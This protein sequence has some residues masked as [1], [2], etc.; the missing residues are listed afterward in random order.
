MT[1]MKRTHAV[2]GAEPQ[3]HNGMQRNR[4][5]ESRAIAAAKQNLE[6]VFTEKHAL[7]GNFDSANSSLKSMKEYD[8]R[9]EDYYFDSSMPYVVASVAHGLIRITALMHEYGLDMRAIGPEGENA[10]SMD[11]KENRGI[12]VKTLLEMGCNPNAVQKGTPA[13]VDAEFYH[14]ECGDSKS[15]VRYLK[16]NGADINALDKF[17][18]NALI[19]AIEHGNANRAIELVEIGAVLTKE[20]MAFAKERD[21]D[22]ASVQSAALLRKDS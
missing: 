8:A 17:N 11:I 4:A 10:I 6:S 1:Y 19:I 15:V 18:R 16:E 22:I 13:I 21:F 5:G 14:E 20:C 2:S 12:N 9:P 3:H 7:Y